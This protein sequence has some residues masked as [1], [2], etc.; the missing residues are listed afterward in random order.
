M[1]ASHNILLCF[2]I[3]YHYQKSVTYPQ[4]KLWLVKFVQLDLYRRP[5]STKP[6]TFVDGQS[7]CKPKDKVNVLNQCLLKR[8][9]QHCLPTMDAADYAILEMLTLTISQSLL[10]KLYDSL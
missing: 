5:V 8:I 2:N 3:R 10:G 4:D 9:Y 6:V 1:K 7:V